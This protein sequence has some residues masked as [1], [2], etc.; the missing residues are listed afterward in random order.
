MEETRRLLS[1]HRDQLDALT[2][3]L[4]E[5]ETLDD[6]QVRALLGFAPLEKNP[7]T[8]EA[9]DNEKPAAEEEQ[10]TV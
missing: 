6:A 7:E 8:Q 10:P 1:T 9:T 3:E 5:K 4:I 2:N